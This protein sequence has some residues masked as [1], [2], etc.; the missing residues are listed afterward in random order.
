M[1]PFLNVQRS[2]AVHN[3]RAKLNNAGWSDAEQLTSAPVALP[4]PA[5]GCFGVPAG[6]NSGGPANG[7]TIASD[8]WPLPDGV[9][10]GDWL[11]AQLDAFIENV[12]AGDAVFWADLQFRDAYHTDQG[13]SPWA[14]SLS[15][16]LTEFTHVAGMIEVSGSGATEFRVYLKVDDDKYEGA[17]LANLYFTNVQVE[18]CYFRNAAI[19][20][21]ADGD[22]TDWVWSGTEHD[23]ESHDADSAMIGYP[24]IVPVEVIRPGEDYTLDPLDDHYVLEVEF[25]PLVCTVTCSVMEGAA[26]LDVPFASPVV[27]GDSFEVN[28]T[29]A[30]GYEIEK[31]KVNG[32]VTGLTFTD[33]YSIANVSQDTDID[34]YFQRR[35]V[36]LE[37]AADANGS[38]DGD[39][40]QT[41]DYGG[42]G[43]RVLAVP[44][45]GYH[46]EKWSDDKTTIARV[47]HNV[48]SN[49]SVTAS[50]VE[51]EVTEYDLVYTAGA[52]GSIDGNAA[53]VVEEYKNGEEVT[54]VPDAGYKFE[55]WSDNVALKAKRIDLIIE[56]DLTVT[57]TFVEA[58]PWTLTYT[59]GEGGSLEGDTD[60][61]V[62]DGA[63]GTAVTAVPASGYRFLAWDD[64]YTGRTR[65]DAGVSADITVEASFE[66]I[67]QFTLSYSAGTGGSIEGDTS[68][69]VQRGGAGTLVRAVPSAGYRFVAWSDGMLT[70]NRIDTGVVADVT[71][72]ATF[73]S[74]SLVLYY[75]AISGGTIVGTAIQTVAVGGNGSAVTATPKAHYEFVRW[76]DGV[77]T[78]TRT[79]TNVLADKHL[80]ARFELETFAL[81]YSAGSGGSL[82]GDASQTVKWN[83]KGMPVT[84]IP[85]AGYHF[86]KWSDDVL[87]ERRT[88]ENVSANIT[89][90]ASFEA[91]T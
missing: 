60:Q 24:A 76:S 68:Q 82:R 17:L 47:D 52:Y 10:S 37:Y 46:F 61:T 20:E 40:S 64:G 26:E 80:L 85:D 7:L 32:M 58:G 15:V 41:V 45:A 74:N 67:G 28:W 86:V 91:D 77:L 57:A 90:T 3:P 51:G 79:D 50:F 39:A 35:W 66:E 72:S 31:L 70:P 16:S 63:A 81:S 22:S 6:T 65:R 27:N 5:D 18:Q 69:D 36:S 25:G 48:T 34:I 4:A 87:T 21:Y 23:S 33:K 8:W 89:V 71:V 56:E 43:T 1:T 30:T 9:E 83:R 11:Y 13:W 49:L 75:R 42:M 59:A 38:I 88:D 78:A 53:Q 55:K 44:D 29:P 19:P 12:A 14:R 73:N 2:N 62:A 84:A 54:A